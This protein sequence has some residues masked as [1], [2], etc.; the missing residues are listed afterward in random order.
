[1]I[2]P[3]TF[4]FTLVT[5]VLL[6]LG[7]QNKKVFLLLVANLLWWLSSLVSL[8]FTW[9]VWN[10]RGY[11]EHWAFYGFFYLALP[12]ILAIGIMAAVQLVLLRHRQ[13]RY[14]KQLRLS[15]LFLLL[16]LVFQLVVGFAYG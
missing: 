4:L 12:N 15:S 9:M 16:F 5:V 1:M 3:I 13:S 6:V 11:S 2:G 7:F 8:Y 14:I 10:D